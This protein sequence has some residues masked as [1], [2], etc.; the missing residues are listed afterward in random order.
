MF[1]IKRKT[2]QRFAIVVELFF[3]MGLTWIAEIAR[4][5]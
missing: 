1:R 5:E 2:K 4:L 3:V